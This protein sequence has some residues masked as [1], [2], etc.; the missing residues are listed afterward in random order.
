MDGLAGKASGVRRDGPI[1]AGRSDFF[2]PL[3]ACS[4]LSSG[5]I[6]GENYVT[7]TLRAGENCVTL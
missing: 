5:Q 3:L 4:Y 7:L 1:Q 2:I 6:D